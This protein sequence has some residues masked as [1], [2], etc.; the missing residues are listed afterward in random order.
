MKQSK[1]LKGLRV[2]LAILFFVPIFLYFVDFAN[3]LPE[4][5]HNLLHIQLV[6]AIL[7]GIIWILIAQFLLVLVFGRIYCSVICPA[8]VLQDIINRIYCIGKKKKRGSRRFVFRKPLNWLRYGLLG[9][10]AVFAIFG[11]IELLLLLDPYSNFG[12]IVSNLFRPLVMWGNNLIAD[13]LMK[14]DNYT[15]YHVTVESG[16]IPAVIAGGSILL[17]FILLV[18]LRGR[19]FCNTLCPVGA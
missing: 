19:L 5:L 16:T 11:S 15:L 13:G 6:P 17:L 12:R 9:L 8:G 1:I 7:A 2:L 10:T 18:T 14:F 4:S 3:L